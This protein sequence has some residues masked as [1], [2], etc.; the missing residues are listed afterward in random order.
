MAWV[1]ENLTDDRLTL[2]ISP[3]YHLEPREVRPVFGISNDFVDKHYAE[4]RIKVYMDSAIN[5]TT[6]D[7]HFWPFSLSACSHVYTF[8]ANG[9]VLTDTATDSVLGFVRV[10]TF[11]YAASAPFGAYPTTK[12]VWVRTVTPDIAKRFGR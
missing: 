6:F 11:T 4:G 8:D 3:A 9:N 1:V 2:A 10:Q 5:D 12:S 7:D